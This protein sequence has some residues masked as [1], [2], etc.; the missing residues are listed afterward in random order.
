[1]APK[2]AEN[3]PNPTQKLYLP[4]QLSQI[5]RK[6]KDGLYSQNTGRTGPQALRRESCQT[7]LP[8]GPL[9]NLI[10]S[11]QHLYFPFT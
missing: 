7:T 3:R 10:V 9:L 1:M 2:K 5:K 4:R 8:S 6:A 11:R